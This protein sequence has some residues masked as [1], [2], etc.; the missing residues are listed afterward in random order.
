M[1][2]KFYLGITV[3]VLAI[4]GIMVNVASIIILMLRKGTQ[5][6]FHHLLKLL[7]L[8]DLVSVI[9]YIVKN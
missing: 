1:A 4:F 2:D 3:L 5:Q 6:M 9:T 8:Y 7:A